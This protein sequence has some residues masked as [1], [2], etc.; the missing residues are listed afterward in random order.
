MTV[1]LQ[2]RHEEYEGQHRARLQEEEEEARR[3]AEFKVC[4]ESL[5]CPVP[6]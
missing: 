5:G 4:A 3:A 6:T 1:F 2:A